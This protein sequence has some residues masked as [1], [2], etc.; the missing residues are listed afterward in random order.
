MERIHCLQ[1]GVIGQTRLRPRRDLRASFEDMKMR[2]LT[3]PLLKGA[4]WPSSVAGVPQ[5]PLF[6]F[7]PCG[8]S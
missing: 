8:P 2:G 4:T 3:D 1:C 5:S 6:V 7:T